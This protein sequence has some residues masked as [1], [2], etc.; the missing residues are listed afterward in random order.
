MGI[1]YSLDKDL[2]CIMM[3]W[4]GDVTPY[5]W[6]RHHDTMFA[7]P[8]YPSGR[9][10]LADVR[11][12]G[13]LSLDRETF[14]AMGAQLSEKLER[15]PLDQLAIVCTVMWDQ[16][17]MFIEHDLAGSGVRRRMFGSPDLACRWLG[18]QAEAVLPRLAK[19]HVEASTT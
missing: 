1:A 14:A 15:F 19:L 9:V 6:R 8:Q 16:V 2:G 13:G 10:A 11:G 17:Q 3:V 5:Q 18:L 7:D 12:T 4:Y